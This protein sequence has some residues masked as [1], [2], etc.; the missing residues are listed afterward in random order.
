[1]SV[2]VSII[3]PVKN[4]GKFLEECLESILN[5]DFITWE[6]IAINDNSTD[7]SAQLLK[8]YQSK[9]SRIKY[10]EN[11]GNGI[12]EALRLAFE[13]SKGSYITRMDAD[14]IM[15]PE[16]LTELIDALNASN[17]PS[18]STGLVQYFSENELGDGYKR[19]QDWLNALTKEGANFQE[20]YKECVIPSP[21]WMLKRATLV[22]IGAFESNRYPEDYDLCFRMYAAGL[23]VLGVN[24]ILHHWRDYGERASRND[25]NYAD[26]RFLA[27][28]LQYFIELEYNKNGN[29]FIW[30]AGRKG[31]EVAQYF[32]DNNI[33][34]EWYCDNPKKIGK[35]IY[36]VVMKD[37]ND[38]LNQENFQCILLVANHDEQ[39]KIKNQIAVLKGERQ[40]FYWFC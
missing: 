5:Q 3:M 7:N 26:N 38:M 14:D 4:A 15:S 34:F 11:S 8:A 27:L 24:K 6:L 19:Y 13:K 33:V 22:D 18:V 32:I 23:K 30:G 39:E 21:C 20:I 37:A 9:D 12:I 35:D 29:L 36:G 1:M 2:D 25:A 40:E 16:R 17:E 28:K 10:F 31:K